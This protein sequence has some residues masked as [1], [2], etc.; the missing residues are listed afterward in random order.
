MLPVTRRQKIKEYVQEKKSATVL[1]L[2]AMYSV[3]DE[4]IR[5]DLKALEKEGALM[6]TY[7]GAFLQTGV[8]NLVEADLRAGIYVD[9]KKRIAAICRGLIQNGDALFL[10]N[11]TTCFY[12]AQAV[13]DMRLTIVTNSLT[14]MN[15]LA[16]K[17]NL[18]L[19]SPGG[20]FSHSEKAFYGA[21]TVNTLLEYY[22]DKAFISCRSLSIEHGITD[23]MER[24]NRVRQAAV[25]RSKETYLVADFSKFNETSFMR[26]CGFDSIT[27]IITDKPLSEEWHSAMGRWNCKIFDRPAILH[28]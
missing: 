28:A 5:R 26:L 17:D 18:R 13:E 3:T 20:V 10:D 16:P 2:A 8:E 6:R 15:Q 1:A 14:I 27:A 21:A 12:I 19:I 23:S 4:T 9:N 22:V 11:S 7:G 24:W 25:E